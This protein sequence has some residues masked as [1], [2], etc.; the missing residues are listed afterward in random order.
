M[1]N[2]F[3]LSVSTLALLSTVMGSDGLSA[4]ASAETPVNTG[5]FSWLS[6]GSTTAATAAPDPI[7]PA[8]KVKPVNRSKVRRVI[9]LGKGMTATVSRYPEELP[10][11]KR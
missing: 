10:N 7:I 6:R 5:W 1:N 9:D 3:K 11:N 8:E 2:I 4:T